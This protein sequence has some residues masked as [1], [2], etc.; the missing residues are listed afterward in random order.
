MD[1][2]ELEKLAA[3]QFEAVIVGMEGS[4]EK[5][6]VRS[7]EMEWERL[8]EMVEVLVLPQGAL[9]LL[10]EELVHF[11]HFLQDTYQSFALQ[12]QLL[13]MGHSNLLPPTRSGSPGLHPHPLRR[14]KQGHY[15][16]PHINME[17]GVILNG[18]CI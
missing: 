3:D 5:D 1:Q 18:F 13:E 9:I 4:I 2:S 10:Q 12:S 7:T 15:L 6:G 16:L 14:E 11:D 17:L 8:I